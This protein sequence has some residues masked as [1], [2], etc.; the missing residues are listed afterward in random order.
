MGTNHW[1]M[2]FSII[3]AVSF[4]TDCATAPAQAQMARVD[5][6]STSS[7][8]PEQSGKSSTIKK[9]SS[10]EASSS[11]VTEKEISVVTFSGSGTTKTRPFTVNGPWEIQW[12]FSGS[13]FAVTIYNADGS[14]FDIGGSQEG[15]GKGSSYQP[16]KGNYYLKIMTAGIWELKVVEI[17]KQPTTEKTVNDGQPTPKVQQYKP[18]LNP[19]FFSD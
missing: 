19:R 2:M 16:K 18:R 15:S 8:V 12:S 6:Q 13:F 9:D 11:E 17:R 14:V 1:L 10:D 5:N 3:L 7:T 4:L